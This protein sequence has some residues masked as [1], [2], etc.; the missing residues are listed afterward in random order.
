MDLKDKQVGKNKSFIAS[1][2]HAFRGIVTVFKE[3]RN[4]R[5]H[6]LSAV[7]SL[8]LCWLFH[9]ST[10]EWF[11]ILFCCFLV[12]II[13]VLN[14]V[15][16]NIVDLVTGCSYHPIAKKAKDMAAAAV[17]IAASFSLLIGCIVFLPKLIELF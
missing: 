13:E 7:L 15:V 5:S 11:M 4:M 8:V 9:V 1:L 2:K 12:I 6:L 3:E 10:V 17:L 16:E 14:T